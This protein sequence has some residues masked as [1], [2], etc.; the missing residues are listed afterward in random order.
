MSRKKK[1]KKEKEK[2]KSSY[3]PIYSFRQLCFIN[4]L[5]YNVRVKLTD[6]KIDCGASSWQSL[7]R[8]GSR[9][10][11][12][13]VLAL[14]FKKKLTRIRRR[15]IFNGITTPPFYR[16]GTDNSAVGQAV[17]RPKR[18]HDIRTACHR[19][20][21]STL[22]FQFPETPLVRKKSKSTRQNA[23]PAPM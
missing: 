5:A 16:S 15:F 18:A 12:L 4:Q 19:N 7:S 8:L 14:F 10:C 1:E 20:C 11:W 17:E 23:E 9:Y 21:F 22:L 13:I 3:D 6:F 2:S